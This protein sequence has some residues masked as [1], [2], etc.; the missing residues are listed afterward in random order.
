MSRRLLATIVFTL[1]LILSAAEVFAIFTARNQYDYSRAKDA[2]EELTVELRLISASIHSGDKT[3]MQDSY[4]RYRATLATFTDNEYVHRKQPELLSSLQ[5][6]NA[7]IS[8]NSVELDELLELSA[9]LS[10][11]RSELI[12]IDSAELDA[13]HFYQIQQTFQTLNDSLDDIRSENLSQVKAR[14]SS[15]SQKII[16]LAKSSAICVSVCSKTNFENKQKQI[17]DI[18]AHYEEEFKTLGQDISQKYSPSELI[19]GLQNI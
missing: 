10:S 11:I 15:F 14:L 9:A 8:E 18:K 19:A 3:L 6:Y 1:A 16:T 5:K 4:A 12:D 7:V 13:A 2:A 17:A